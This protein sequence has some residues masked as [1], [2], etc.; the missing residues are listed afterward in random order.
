M[1]LT[2]PD[3]IVVAIL[4]R[5]RPIAP[6]LAAVSATCRR[7][8]SI[9]QEDSLWRAAAVVV[10]GARA[11]R[12]LRLQTH[13]TFLRLGHRAQVTVHMWEIDQDWCRPPVRVGRVETCR[14]VQAKPAVAWPL[15]AVATTGALHAAACRHAMRPPY[16]C[17]VWV[18]QRHPKRSAQGARARLNAC[19]PH[20][21]SPD[22]AWFS[23]AP[24]GCDTHRRDM[25]TLDIYI[26]KSDAETQTEYVPESL[27][28]GASL[29]AD[30][31][32]S[33]LAAWLPLETFWLSA[34]A[35]G[36]CHKQ[37]AE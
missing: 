23:L 5:A 14:L 2:M 20:V 28:G 16:S 26:C 15:L 37:Q 36:V 34:D 8:A 30:G 4:A 3:E 9:C 7:L 17:R 25:L 31:E 11:V 22:K 18:R 12:A 13:K 24:T 1:L 6:C 10:M 29:D 33:S 21:R 35:C 27:P 32:P 19:G